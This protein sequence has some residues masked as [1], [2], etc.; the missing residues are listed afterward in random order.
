MSVRPYA[1]WRMSTQT[2]APPSITRWVLCLRSKRQTPPGLLH[3]SEAAAALK[4]AAVIL[5]IHMLLLKKK[6]EKSTGG[7]SFPALEGITDS[8]HCSAEV[9][10]PACVPG[11]CERRGRRGGREEESD[12]CT[13]IDF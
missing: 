7:V 1:R 3:C 10:E 5:L 8:F 13:V 4:T 2:R 12:T 11:W 6:K 9:S